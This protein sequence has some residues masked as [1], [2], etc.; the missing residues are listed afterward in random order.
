MP[1][2]NF[3]LCGPLGRCAQPDKDGFETAKRLGFTIILK[4]NTENEFPLYIE[5]AAFAPGNV[6]VVPM[7]SFKPDEK[8]I[9]ALIGEIQLAL[10]NGAKILV[11][12]MAGRDRTGFVCAAYRIL[13]EGWTL[14]KVWKE[15]KQYGWTPFSSITDHAIHECLEKLVKK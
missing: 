6:W 8:Q 12:C 1:L 13:V 4:L 9:R 5:A 15:M 3:G 11:H 14:D 7:N 2:N 10:A